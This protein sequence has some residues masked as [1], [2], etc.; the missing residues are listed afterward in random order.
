MCLRRP[1]PHLRR[2]RL[3]RPEVVDEL[4]R[5]QLDA[6]R[7]LLP[8]PAR[9]HPGGD[10]LRARLEPPFQV[11][12]LFPISDPIREVVGLVEE[13]RVIQRR[14]ARLALLDS[15]GPGRRGQGF[16][17][18]VD[19]EP[20]DL[21]VGCGVAVD[22][23]MQDA[24]ERLSRI[25]VHPDEVVETLSVG[26][27][28][29]DPCPQRSL[30][31]NRDTGRR[32]RLNGAALDGDGGGYGAPGDGAAGL[33]LHAVQDAEVL[34]RNLEADGARVDRHPLLPVVDPK[35]LRRR[36]WRFR[37]NVHLDPSV[38]LEVDT[39]V[40]EQP[41]NAAVG[42]V[43]EG[44]RLGRGA[45]AA[46]VRHGDGRAVRELAARKRHREGERP[47]TARHAPGLADGKGYGQR[48]PMGGG[49][50]DRGSADNGG[51]RQ[52]RGNS[53]SHGQG[54]ERSDCRA[55]P[56]QALDSPGPGSR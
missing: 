12:L 30:L 33:Q 52:R 1:H 46:L 43:G 15:A 51:H 23:G 22:E 24:H 38:R 50:C 26:A 29:L 28:Q 5:A 13:N 36:R 54:G 53:L 48:R 39:A 14:G 8:E 2:P 11:S 40:D 19:R 17:R 10:L 56:Q 42:P 55:L 49:S 41:A 21:D 34:L 45:H 37:S 4:L 20:R 18:N 9:R 27:A 25:G 3:R 6:L 44:P 35:R 7:I 31:E 16:Q 47:L 32:Q